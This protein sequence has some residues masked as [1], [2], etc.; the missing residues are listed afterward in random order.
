[1]S[2]MSCVFTLGIVLTALTVATTLE[3]QP[4]IIGGNAVDIAKYPYLVSIRY[5][6]EPNIDP[7]WHKCAGVILTETAVLTAAQCLREILTERVMIAVAANQRKGNEGKLYPA[8]KW[9]EHP[10]FSTYTADY[11]IG[12]IFVDLPFEFHGSRTMA[13]SISIR[14]ER[15]AVNRLATVAGWGYREEFGPSSNRLEET[16]VPIVSQAECV[17]IYGAG[18]VSE[19]MICAGNVR[20]GG[21]DACQGDTGGPLVYEGELVGLVSWGRGCARPG[22]PSVY[23]YAASLKSWI[24]EELQKAQV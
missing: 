5:R 4:A 9:V 21:H 2:R 14:A 15:P 19:R 17:D 11:D 22:Y 1:M 10:K 16:K 24:A 6:L 18:E 13:R 8:S 12:L 3:I 7:Y 20:T 23:T